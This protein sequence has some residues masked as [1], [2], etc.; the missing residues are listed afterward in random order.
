[1]STISNKAKVRRRDFLDKTCRLNSIKLMLEA[2]SSLT[3]VTARYVS[4]KEFKIGL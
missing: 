2:I 1:M 3:A 4:I